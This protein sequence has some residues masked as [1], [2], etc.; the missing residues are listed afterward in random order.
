ELN[1]VF[2]F[3]HDD[4]DT[5]DGERWAYRKV[6]LPELKAVLSKWQIAMNGKAWNSLYWTNHDQPRTVSRRGDDGR[7]RKESQ[8]M[9]YTML[10]TMQGTPYIYQGEEIGMTNVSFDSIEDYDDVEIHNCWRERV[11][12]GN[13]DPEKLLDGIRYRARDNA[14]TPMQWD[15]SEN[16]G[17]TTG[18]PWLKV[19]PNYREINAASQVNDPDSVFSFYRRLIALRKEYAAFVDGEFELLYAEDPDIFAY[20]RT[21]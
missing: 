16:A 7:Y 13:A 8:K 5:V 9:L 1:M 6:P 3:E 12:N 18:T 20:T 15:D 14:R 19:N 17:F 10:M 2:Q 11:I 21:T 4:L